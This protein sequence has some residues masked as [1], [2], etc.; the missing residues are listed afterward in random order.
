MTEQDIGEI[1]TLTEIVNRARRNLDDGTWVMVAGGAE[2]ETTLMRNRQALD[3]VAFAPRVLRDVRVVDASSAY[4]GLPQR[5]PVLLAPVGT[6]AQIDPGGALPV[7]GAGEEFG[8]TAFI[9]S[10]AP[11]DMAALRSSTK[12]PPIYQLYVVGDDDWL[13]A[14]IDQINELG[15]PAL[16]LTV[17]A[18]T[19]SRNIEQRVVPPLG[20]GAGAQT[21]LAQ[22]EGSP[23]IGREFQAAL[24]WKTIDMIRQRSRIPLIL[25]GISAVADAE[26]AVEHGVASIYV[27][28]HGGRQ[29]D[30]G[31]GTMELLPEIVDRVGGRVE[32]MVDGGFMRGTDIVKAIAA[33]ATAVGIGKLYCYGLAAG[34]QAGVV[35]VLELLEEEIKN[36]MGLLGVTSLD[37]L[38]PSYLHPASPVRRPSA[39][40]ALPL[41][42]LPA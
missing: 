7:A 3:E 30:H 6:V 37:Q 16:C 12:T 18:A 35:R 19:T 22:P 9:S 10:S 28:N 2:T 4:L 34:G 31:A 21:R 39:F 29:L 25:K 23:Q 24:T 42:D 32:I 13:M 11:P 8:V 17:D 5:M 36:A 15:Y 41:A 20:A 27:S 38:N 40:S 1:S 14:Q 26:M 33:G